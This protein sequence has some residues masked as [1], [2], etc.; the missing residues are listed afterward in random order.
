MYYIVVDVGSLDKSLPTRVIGIYERRA[1]ADTVARMA[2]QKHVTD[3]W[4]S[5]ERR[6]MVC[7][8]PILA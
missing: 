1:D 4:Q 5:N 7:E 2:R 8:T 3:R 6:V